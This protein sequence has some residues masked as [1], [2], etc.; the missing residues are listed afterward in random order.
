[1]ELN[2]YLHY[3]VHRERAAD[4]MRDA[5]RWRLIKSLKVQ[6]SSPGWLGRLGLGRLVSVHPDDEAG[7]PVPGARQAASSPTP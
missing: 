2:P 7:M 6:G 1:M 3:L 5:E 4:A